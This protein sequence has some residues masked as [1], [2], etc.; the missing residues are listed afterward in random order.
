[1]EDD[2]ELFVSSLD[3]H[4]FDQLIDRLVKNIVYSL[5][6]MRCCGQTDNEI[7]ANLE[8]LVLLGE[9]Y[10]YSPPISHRVAREWREKSLEMMGWGAGSSE[11]Y[12]ERKKVIDDT[13]D[14]LEKL[15]HK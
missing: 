10:E 5:S 3:Y 8:I 11:F 6:E 4:F 2:H 15:I 7:L 13:F 14:R 1:M 9:H 12:F